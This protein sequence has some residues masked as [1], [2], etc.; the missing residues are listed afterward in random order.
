MN[1]LDRASDKFSELVSQFKQNGLESES[2]AELRFQFL[3]AVL[4]EVLGWSRDDICVES[5]SETGYADYLLKLKPRNAA[6]IEAKRASTELITTAKGA[7]A[8]YILRG[9]VLRPAIPGIMQAKGYASDHGCAL[10]AVTTGI[11]WIV[12]NP[13]RRDSLDFL[14]GHAIVLPTLESIEQD[15]GTFYDLLS[16]EAV[17]ERR[18][19]IHLGRAEG[20]MMTP[21]I[22]WVRPIEDRK[23]PLV[24][25][26]P[27]GRDLDKIFDRFFRSIV[28]DTDQ[29]MLIDCFVE[30]KE[31]RDADVTL[32]KI[33]EELLADISS[34]STS[35]GE[36]LKREI[37][38]TIR[39]Q[40]SEIVLII[41]NKGAGKTTFIDRFYSFVLP[42]ALR[43]QCVVARAD[44]ADATQEEVGIEAWLTERLIGEIEQRLFPD[45]VP[46]Y[47]NLQGIYHREYQ[48]WCTG[49]H[50]YLYERDKTEFKI[51]FG[52]FMDR[53]R[54]SDRLSYLKRL[55]TTANRQRSLLPCLIF[56][57]TDQFPQAFQERVYQYAY[58]LH[59]AAVAFVVVPITDRTI[60]QLSKAGPLQSYAT[61]SF[62]LPVPS[63]KE[64]L[65]KRVT[66]IRRRATEEKRGGTYFLSRGI[67]VTIENIIGFAA[68]VEDLFIRREFVARKISW[69]SNGDLRR[70]LE[71]TRRIVTSPVMRIDELVNAYISGYS[72]KINDGQIMRA[73]ILN[74]HRFFDQDSN[75]FVQNCFDMP[76]DRLMSPLLRVSILQ[77]LL[78][79]LG[80]A[81][82]EPTEQYV[83]IVKII[84]Y[85]EPCGVREQ[86]VIAAVEPLISKRLAEPYDPT[87]ESI[88]PAQRIRITLAGRI[89]LEMLF[90]DQQYINQMAM[91]TAIRSQAIAD[92]IRTLTQATFPRDGSV[93]REV[94]LVFT[95]YLLSEDEALMQLPKDMAYESQRA[96]RAE[97]KARWVVSPEALE[98]ELR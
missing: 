95:E 5:A 2:E 1:P 47:E 34:L 77:L 59:K 64:I 42:K 74:R 48:G 55:L 76:R 33:T 57:N 23:N 69:L 8:S 46:S 91:R 97:L 54:R 61:K 94:S 53:E 56:D 27:L 18:Y 50:K 89:H 25:L 32:Q 11:A 63:T 82:N 19:A 93:W 16:K 20:T 81:R 24:P 6:V 12:F 88:R 26:T 92:K 68:A 60:W 38:E 62:Y 58:A 86:D 80:P 79:A 44:L 84:E 22:Q 35:T 52:D 96:L 17:A 15:F 78:D 72:F 4:L 31:S 43:E 36:E 13:N 30:S 29:E 65:E 90:N 75:D 14:E 39:A 9:P 28:D 49:E 51:R 45:G 83:E 98:L 37:E 41:G 10:A 3:D 85:F 66:Y 87:D 71:L 7:R 67:R 70:G 21:N 73:L 40:T